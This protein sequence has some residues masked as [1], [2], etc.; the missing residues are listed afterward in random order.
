MNTTCPLPYIIYHDGTDRRKTKCEAK[1]NTQ[2]EK[3]LKTSKQTKTK[4]VITHQNLTIITPCLNIKK[5]RIGNKNK[6][7]SDAHIQAGICYCLITAVQILHDIT[8]IA[9]LVFEIL[10]SLHSKMKGKIVSTL[11]YINSH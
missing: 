5:I 6:A 3:T 2:V 1:E 8:S 10:W 7:L 11:N 9:V 4:Q